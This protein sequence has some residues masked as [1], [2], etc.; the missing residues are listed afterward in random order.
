MIGRRIFGTPAEREHILNLI[1]VNCEISG[2][3]EEIHHLDVWLEDDSPPIPNPASLRIGDIEP[4]DDR[5]WD[6]RRHDAPIFVDDNLIV[7]PPWIESPPGFKGTEL[8]VPRGMAFGSGEHESTQLALQCLRKVLGGGGSFADVGTG[9][10]ILALYASHR[11]CRPIACCDLEVEAVSAA[12]QLV[13]EARVQQAGPSGLVEEGLYDHVASN[14]FASEILACATDLG[15]LWN[16]RGSLVVA[17]MRHDE[18]D[19]VLDRLPGT[20]TVVVEGKEFVAV[21]LS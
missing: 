19:E 12:R 4:A 1:W 6:W 20:P 8:V 11:G 5:T 7:R 2:V 14:M 18:K 16:R 10:G 17:G 13:P 21:A 3:A 9:S 15:H